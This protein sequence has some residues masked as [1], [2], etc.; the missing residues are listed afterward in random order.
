M[1]MRGLQF[2]CRAARK[3][4]KSLWEVY[5]LLPG[6]VPFPLGSGVSEGIRVGVGKGVEEG[7][8]VWV[9]GITRVPCKLSRVGVGVGVAGT[10]GFGLPHPKRTFRRTRKKIRIGLFILITVANSIL[11]SLIPKGF[12]A[13]FSV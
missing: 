12:G 6:Q 11:P 7:R 3:C 1:N 9:G 8:R 13:L 4:E 5:G 10:A 2:L